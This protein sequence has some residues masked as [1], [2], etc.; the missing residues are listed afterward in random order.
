M[1]APMN[2]GK[3]IWLGA[4]AAA[5]SYLAYRRR[6]NLSRQPALLE[7]PRGSV[8]EPITVELEGGELLEVVSVGQGPAFLLVSGLSGDKE[9][10][11][12]QIGP[13]SERY[14]VIAIDLRDSFK[15][16]KAEFD[17]FARDLAV[18]LDACGET[19][20]IVLGLSFGAPIAMRF[21]KLYPERVSRLILSNALARLDLSHVGFN[22]TLLIPF[23]RLSSRFLPEFMV[24]KLARYWGRLG[25]WVYDP[26]PGNDRIVEYELDSPRRVPM[27]E[28]AV[29]MDTFRKLDLRDD[30]LSIAQPALV[31]SGA[32]DGYTP[33]AWQRE[34]A[35][36]LPNSTYVEIPRAGHLALI[37][38][39]VTFNKVI[40]D[41][42]AGLEGADQ[43]PSPPPP[44]PLKGSEG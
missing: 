18:V 10:F 19:S 5:G 2:L 38:Q 40:L 42:L 36:L 12:Y 24:R 43:P 11:K 6:S 4:G 9:V 30:L 16:V 32:A 44:P 39:A 37:S 21:A 23:A 14:K 15:G 7:D 33:P 41:W 8:L 13:F 34:I 17:Q 29:R 31:I 35:R 27:S 25:V 22:K 20:A 26:S 28:G 1:I 3:L